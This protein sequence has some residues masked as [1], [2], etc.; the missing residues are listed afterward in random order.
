MSVL[1]QSLCQHKFY[2]NAK[3]PPTCVYCGKVD[4]APPR[5]LQPGDKVLVEGTIVEGEIEGD[6]RSVVR[7]DKHGLD[8]LVSLSSI[9]PFPQ[10]EPDHAN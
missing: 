4:K 8:V 2:G 9:R 7:F 1:F 3:Q 6:G 5:P 10:E